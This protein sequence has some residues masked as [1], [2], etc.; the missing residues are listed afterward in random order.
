MKKSLFCVAAMALAV[1]CSND[2]VDDFGIVGEEATSAETTF[3]NL[4]LEFEQSAETRISVT[5]GETSTDDWKATWEY[6]DEICVYSIVNNEYK[7]LS[8]NGT[9]FS[10]EVYTGENRIY[11]KYYE[12]DELNIIEDVDGCYIGLYSDNNIF[13]NGG[14]MPVVNEDV[15]E[16]DNETTDIDVVMNQVGAAIDLRLKFSDLIEGLDLILTGINLGGVP[17]GGND[18]DYTLVPYQIWTD[19]YAGIDS[20]DFVHTSESWDKYYS[21]YTPITET[22]TEYSVQ[23]G[24]LPF[25]IEDGKKLNV[26]LQFNYAF[27]KSF[28]V[29][30]DGG[31][32]FER[33]THSY[34]EYKLDLSDLLD[35]DS[36]LLAATEFADDS[37]GTENDPIEITSAAELA[38]LSLITLNGDYNYGSYYEL[39]ANI[40]LSGKKWYPIGGSNNDFYGHF[41]GNNNT[42]SNLTI[43][44]GGD[45]L[46]LF[47]S[48][49]NASISDLTIDTPAISGEGHRVGA[50]CGLA[51]ENS[52]S[53]G[54]AVENGSVAGRFYVGGVIGRAEFSS[55][56][57]DCHNS[58]STIS[59]TEDNIG[60]ISGS[61]S[62][63][64]TIEEC[65]NT[66]SVLGTIMLEEQ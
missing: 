25:T 22:D 43:D 19:P 7:T 65:Y 3:V 58:N 10:G 9:S 60:G 59:G 23:F 2:V 37:E 20:V 34:L 40:D 31:F 16:I 32:E 56:E 17:E 66:G 50:I 44:D 12:W 24:T 48:I 42:I 57:S 35:D 61:I 33:G 64:S 54:C 18:S 11:H 27:T 30:P 21:V 15:I 53:S 29:A 45:N 8:F 38:Y 5:T 14:S 1:G 13:S 63:N 52:T 4:N 41:D 46:G 28:D 36:W 39:T 55:T 49:Y 6:G 51:W 62:D 47:G 26:T